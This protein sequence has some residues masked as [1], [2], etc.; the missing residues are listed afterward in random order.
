[1]PDVRN[2]AWRRTRPMSLTLRFT[3][4]A[5]RSRASRQQQHKRHRG[6]R[7]QERLLVRS[8]RETPRPAGLHPRHGRRNRALKTTWKVESRDGGLPASQAVP[9]AFPRAGT[10]SAVGAD[11]STGAVAH[12]ARGGRREREREK[13]TEKKRES[14]KV[15][16]KACSPHA[17]RVRAPGKTVSVCCSHCSRCTGGVGSAATPQQRCPDLYATTARAPG[18]DVERRCGDWLPCLRRQLK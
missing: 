14:G 11:R 10:A 3:S 15:G 9:Q 7:Q 13:D 16:A 5:R 1:M 4:Q 17:R 18:T 2:L 6:H 12:L 8:R